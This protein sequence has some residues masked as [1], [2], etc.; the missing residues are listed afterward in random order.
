[1]DGGGGSG[2]RRRRRTGWGAVVD[3]DFDKR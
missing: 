3:S 2:G 1:M